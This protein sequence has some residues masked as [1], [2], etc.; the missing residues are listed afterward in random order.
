MTERAVIAALAYVHLLS[1]SLWFGGLFG[2]VA[3]V[4]PAVV[5]GAEGSFPRAALARIAMRTGPWIYLGMAS[6]VASFAGLWVMG[7][8]AVRAPWVA[9]YAALLM[10]LV[11]NNLYGSAVTWPRL[12]LLPQRLVRREWFWFRLR[13]GI[14]L[15]VGLVLY[16]VAIVAR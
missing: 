9:G 15:V 14:S 6:A 13:M 4:W 12:M 16:S 2:Y 11:A 8:I 10:A 5:S 7:G 1:L 3:C